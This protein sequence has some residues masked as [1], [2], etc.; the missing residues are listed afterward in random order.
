MKTRK[1]SVVLV[2]FILVLVFSG[3][4]HQGPEKEAH[5]ETVGKQPT[6]DVIVS[7]PVSSSDMGTSPLQGTG[8]INISITPGIPN[9]S[10]HV[11]NYTDIRVI[12]QD[13]PTDRIDENR[14]KIR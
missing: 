1:V 11:V 4:I 3:C 8:T 9:A 10:L 12:G 5:N 2:V 13:D 6:H 14:K 7:S